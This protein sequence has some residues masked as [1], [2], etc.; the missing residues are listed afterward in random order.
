M[1][2]FHQKRSFEHLARTHA[3]LR[4]SKIILLFPH[5]REHVAVNFD[6]YR[7]SGIFGSS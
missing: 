5:V 3:K 2:I 4:A 7:K 1:K 6:I